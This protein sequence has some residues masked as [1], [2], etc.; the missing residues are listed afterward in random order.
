[1]LLTLMLIWSF[2]DTRPSN[3]MPRFIA[4]ARQRF[5]INRAARITRFLRR[6][7]TMKRLYHLQIAT[8]CETPAVIEKGPDTLNC[9]GSDAV[10]HADN[11]FS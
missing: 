3:N 9:R 2:V 7:L 8:E 6:Q 1:M 11:P 4:Y 5:S 10:Q